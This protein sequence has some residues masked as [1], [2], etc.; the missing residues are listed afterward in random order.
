M[1][2]N[3]DINIFGSALSKNSDAAGKNKSIMINP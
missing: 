3:Q 2:F 1:A